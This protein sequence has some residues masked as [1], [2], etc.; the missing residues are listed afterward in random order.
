MEN[1]YRRAWLFVFLLLFPE[2]VF[3]QTGLYLPDLQSIDQVIQDFMKK[4]DIPGASVALSKDGRLVYARGF[5]LGNRE[6]G[7]W[8]T[9]ENQ[10]R[11]ASLSKP[12][13]AIAIMQLVQEGK[14]GLDSLVFGENGIL[15]DPAYS[16][17]KDPRTKAITVRQLLQHTAGW[18]RN[19]SGDPMCDPMRIA[20]TLGVPPPADALTIIR[21]M[22]QQPLDFHPGTRFAY[23]NLGYSILG[24]VIEKISG[25]SYRNYVH[26]RIFQP[27]GMSHTVLGRS[28]LSDLNA[29]EVNYYPSPG[30]KEVPSV[31]SHQARVPSPYGGFYLEAMDAHGGW[32][33][34]AS[35]LIRLLTAVDGFDT[36][37]D[38]LSQAS[39]S[40]M[41]EATGNGLPTYALGWYVNERNNWWHSGSLPGSSASLVRTQ[42]GFTW[43][44][45]FNRRSEDVN[46]FKELDK[47]MWQGIR[48]VTT[49]PSHD[50]FEPRVHTDALSNPADLQHAPLLVKEEFD[51]N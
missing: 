31:Y 34:T 3:S 15:S 33:A 19:L 20:E 22:L 4:W 9:P 17:I 32:I 45:L 48:E 26:T 27:L 2:K 12:I 24:R 21:Y 39:I 41:T 1:Y 18:D 42:E 5:G 30:A 38:L 23:S 40:A 35:D 44:I 8:V 46:Y 49:W 50:L 6:T 13:T 37:P 43:C 47:L 7:A 51:S 14:L 28:L 11:I 36:R 16:R 25:L 10:F 29:E